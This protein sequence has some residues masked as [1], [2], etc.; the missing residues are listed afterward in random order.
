MKTDITAN[1]KIL[2]GRD[3]ICPITKVHCD[4]ECCTVGSECNISGNDI[5]DCEKEEIANMKIPITPEAMKELGF[6]EK[7]ESYVFD[8]YGIEIEVYIIPELLVEISL[9]VGW[10][11]VNATTINDIKDLIRLFK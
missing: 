3:M 10:K 1:Q 8:R 2:V 7:K 4:D 9:G 11:E 5:Q 6:E